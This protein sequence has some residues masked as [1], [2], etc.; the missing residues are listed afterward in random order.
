MV[1]AEDLGR[2]S[3]LVSEH[4]GSQ[5]QPVTAASTIPVPVHRCSQLKCLPE[6]PSPPV[7]PSE[8]SEDETK[9]R[10][11]WLDIVPA[12][13]YDSPASLVTLILGSQ[14]N[15]DSTNLTAQLDLGSC[16][17]TSCQV[18][19]AL[20]ILSTATESGALVSSHTGQWTVTQ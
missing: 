17:S 19:L 14:T 9:L 15:A 20:L 16:T 13:T 12:L 3:A 4:S 2:T 5:V 6:V 7:I 11:I 8:E 10:Q 1:E 18:T